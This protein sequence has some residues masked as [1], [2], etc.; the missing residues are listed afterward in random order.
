MILLFITQLCSILLLISLEWG[1]LLYF[2]SEPSIRNQKRS[3][4]LKISQTKNYH[5]IAQL[6]KYIHD[7]HAS[8]YPDFFKKYS[9]HDSQSFFKDIMERPEFIFL[10]L[11]ED[12]NPLGYAMIEL[13]NYPERI[14][15]KPYQSVFV[16]HISI[17]GDQKS[18]EGSFAMFIACIISSCI[19]I[20]FF[21]L[22]GFANVPF[23][24]LVISIIALVATFVEAA[25]PK[26]L[27]NVTACFV[28]AILYIA[29]FMIFNGI[30]I[31]PLN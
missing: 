25:T 23:D 10:L 16:H 24:L 4:Y 20:G 31:L 6:N 11:E 18:L 22:F 7:L 2:S 29:Y 26:G 1:S 28:T 21:N 9:F 27:D 14:F 3:E 17:S 8:L 13:R 5:V 19:I 12:E 30:S 15:I